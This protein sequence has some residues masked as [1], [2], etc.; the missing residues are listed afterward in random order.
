MS[1]V[2]KLKIKFTTKI[3]LWFANYVKN[4]S[5]RLKYLEQKSKE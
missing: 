5:K 3:R 4:V 2:I 1:N